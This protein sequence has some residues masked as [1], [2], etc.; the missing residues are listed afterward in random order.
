[1]EAL[2]S[3]VDIKI[4]YQSSGATHLLQQIYPSGQLAYQGGKL[5]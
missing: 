3:S 1:M 4:L 2:K 5:Q